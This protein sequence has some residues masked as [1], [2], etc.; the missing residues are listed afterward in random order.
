MPEYLYQEPL[1]VWRGWRAARR[2]PGYKAARRTWLADL[3]RDKTP[4]RV[5]RFGQALVLAA[6][7][8]PDIDWLY[9]H[10]LHTPAS[11]TRYAA[12]MP[13]ANGAFRRTP[14]TSGPRPNGRSGKSWRTPTWAVTC[15]ALAHAHLA[16][17]APEPGA[18]RLCYHGLALDRFSPAPRRAF[19]CA[20]AVTQPN[21]GD[22]V[23][24]SRGGEK[25][26]RRSAAAL[27]LLPRNLYWRFVH[28]GG[29]PLPAS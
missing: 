11:V 9:A 21:G 25:G 15:T 13:A 7:L 2:L 14:R 8:P 10:F 20:T 6:E 4:N 3:L 12:M 26:L 19:E 28:I 23:G 18:V 24:R 5:R 1:R 27:A 22:L 17:L 16:A 29:G